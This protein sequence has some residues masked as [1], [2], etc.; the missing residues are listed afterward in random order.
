MAEARIVFE[1][2]EVA[3]CP[4]YAVGDKLV[5]ELPGVNTRESSAVCA[6]TVAAAYPLAQAL[7]YGVPFEEIGEGRGDEGIFYCPGGVGKRVVFAVVKSEAG[8]I[9]SL[10]MMIDKKGKPQDQDVEFIVGHLKKID[11]FQPLPVSSIETIIPALELK[12]FAEGASIIQQGAPGEYLY[13]LIKGGV[14]VIQTSEDGIENTL[15]RLER[16]EVF[17][18]MSLLSREPC[19]A[20][21]R[22]GSNVSVL[23]VSRENFHK[24]LDA[25]PSLNIYFN[26][27]LVQRLR[28][29]NVQVDE[30]ISKGVLGNLSM[31]TLPELAQTLN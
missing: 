5:F 27:L 13:V 26:K 12:R 9:P 11:L 19:S 6:Q 4:L 25:Q 22:A 31:I 24:I 15:A 14:D 28:R 2:K 10:T 16:G 7:A 17:G 8:K 1:A 3:D 29:Q 21:V 20:T 30:Q 23:A 18:E